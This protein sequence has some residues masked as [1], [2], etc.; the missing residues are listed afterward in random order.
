MKFVDDEK[1]TVTEMKAGKQ[2][3][4]DGGKGES[5]YNL[6]RSG[7]LSTVKPSVKVVE[8]DVREIEVKRGCK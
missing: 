2:V 4:G 6:Y 7:E 8:N 3:G 5:I 1:K